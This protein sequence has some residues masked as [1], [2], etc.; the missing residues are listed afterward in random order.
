MDEL[1]IGS[2]GVCTEEDSG[3]LYKLLSVTRGLCYLRSI[4]GPLIFRVCIPSNFWP[5]IDSLP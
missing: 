3:R 4:D 1:I 5:L 2:I